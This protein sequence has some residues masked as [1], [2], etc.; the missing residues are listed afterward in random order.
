MP[1]SASDAPPHQ[2]SVAGSVGH[3]GEQG[4]FLPTSPQQPGEEL[5]SHSEGHSLPTKPVLLSTI[6]ATPLPSLNLEMQ[7]GSF[8]HPLQALHLTHEGSEAQRG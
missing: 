4:L 1:W 7:L 5:S 2:V 3:G 8:T 6:L